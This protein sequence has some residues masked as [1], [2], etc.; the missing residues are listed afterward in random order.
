MI[1]VN[2]LKPGITFEYDGQ[3]FVVISAQHSKSGRGQAHVKAKVKNMKSKAIITLTFTGGNKV[4]KAYIDQENVQFLYEDKDNIIFMN[5]DT[6]DQI[7]LPKNDYKNELNFLVEGSSVTIIKYKNEILDFILPTNVV[8]TVK[9]VEHAVKGDSKS[10]TNKKV[11]LETGLEIVVPI[12]IKQGEKII[13]S[14]VDKKYVG[15][16]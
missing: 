7:E 8:L 11:I 3:I 2:D 10:S 16:V 13:V 4:S 5:T 14:T 1:N 12:F 15:R 9:T 6:Y